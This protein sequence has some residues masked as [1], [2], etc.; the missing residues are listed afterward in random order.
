MKLQAPSSKLQ[1]SSKLQ[2]PKA[3]TVKSFAVISALLAANGPLPA[4]QV[5]LFGITQSWKY[6]TNDLSATNWQSA[7]HNDSA[8]P[9]GPALLYIESNTN[10]APRNTPLPTR[11]GSQPYLTYYF[12]TAFNVS[13]NAAGAALTFSNLVDDGA[14]FYLNG[15]EA[16]RLRMPA[17]A[18]G[19]DT[20]ATDRPPGGDA[21]AY[22]VFTIVPTNLIA[23][24]NLLAVEV[25]QF[26]TASSDIVFGTALSETFG[27]LTRGPY[28]QLGT[29]TS[30]VIRWRTDIPTDSQVSYGTNLAG[31]DQTNT[32]AATTTEHEVS[33]TGL[34]PDTRYFYSVG[35]TTKTWAVAGTNQYFITAPLPG[36][37]KPTRIWVIGDAG[38]G[39]A[40]QTAVRDAFYQLTG[41]NHTDL[42][43]QLGDNAYNSGTDGEYQA[44]VFDVYSSLLRTSV[45]WPTLGN[46]DTAQSSVDTNT[47][48]Y[49][50]MFTLP[51]AG[52]AGGEPSSTESYYSF[53]YA[54]IHFICL[55]SMTAN[56]SPTGA[57]AIWLELDLQANTNQWIIAYWHHPPYSKGS[58]D[59]DVELE[60]VEM[61]QNM[62][63]ILEAYGVDLV[64]SGHS[65]AY[66]RSFLLNGHY[67]VSTTLSNTM[68]LNSGKGREEETGAYIKPRGYDIAN[69]GAVYAVAGSSGQISGGLLNH[70]AMCVSANVLGSMLLNVN[71]NRLDAVFLRETAATNDHFTI[72]KANFPPVASNLT[73]TIDADAPA[74]LALAGSD[75]NR[76]AIQFSAASLPVNGLLSGPNPTNGTF[77]YTPARGFTN[78][79]SFAFLVN[80]GATNSAPATVTFSVLARPD[81]NHNGLADAWEAQF[82]ITDP[83][84][85][86]DQDGLSNVQEYW[87]GTD[88][89]D[90]QSWLRISSLA[91]SPSA[92]FTL[93]WPSIG[94]VRYRALFSDGDDAGGFNGLFTPIVRPVAAEM[95]P[96]PVGTAST[97]SFMDDFSLAGFPAHGNRFYRIQVVR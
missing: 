77:V 91:G 63:P 69:Q 86:E 93:S 9:S 73:F 49:F 27:Q 87:A 36:T 82:G 42:W 32:L 80:D 6:S 39:T 76:D 68:I 64:L 14:V 88:P 50:A 17:G 54:N 53:D 21:T 92:G 78:T 89:R 1:R 96:S 15:V 55:N 61:R 56:R 12:R 74:Q 37:A 23:G 41:T 65:H 31:L 90:N 75:V 58:H 79:D 70:P 57:M 38:T 19:Y 29:P 46:H 95:D 71:S 26:D 7:A 81:T 59:S 24:T 45:T 66:E 35:S 2:A 60:L 83:N 20:F 51:T 16:H 10:I 97:M 43:L 72:V 30:I 33:L 52:E 22:D 8:W 85:D 94:G 40:S 44:K 25:H 84:A 62:L 48:P 47:Y 11:N 5:S 28:L 3:A 34:S 18:I 4:A 67:G 13:D